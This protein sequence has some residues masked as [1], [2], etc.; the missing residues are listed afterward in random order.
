MVGVGSILL[1]RSAATFRVWDGMRGIDY[2]RSRPDIDAQRIGCTGNSGGGC[3]TSYLMALDQR[4]DCAAPSCY[5]TSFRRLMETLGPADAEQNIHGQIAHGM[6][7]TDYVLMR[8]PKPTL[9]CAATEDFMDISGSWFNFRQSKRFYTRLGYAERVDLIE[10]DAKHGFSTHLRVGATR[11]MRRWLLGRDDAVTEPDFPVLSDKECLC[12]PE[13][14][15]MF[16]PGARSTFDLNDELAAELAAARR[17]FWRETDTRV[18]LDEVRRITGIR[19]AEEL[20]KLRWMKTGV[21]QRTGYVVD[22]LILRP[23][24]G[25]WLPALAFAPQDVRRDA[26]LYVHGEGKRADAA[27]GGPIEKLVQDGYLVLAVDVRG[28][29]ETANRSPNQRHTG[30]YVGA[31]LDDV[32]IAYELGASYLA[33]RAEDVLACARFLAA[34]RSPDGPRRV[35]LVGIGD[36]GPAAL[37]AAA[38]EPQ[39]FA[40]L[41]LREC[42]L[43]W[44]DVVA[45]RPPD[46]AL[47]IN[48]VHGALRRYDLSD[49]L[50]AIP[51]EKRVVIDPLTVP[52]R[53]WRR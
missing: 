36:V 33:M 3:L 32:N 8:A 20:P 43:S 37:H 24:A 26:Y 22:K 40:S 10:A 12:A 6:G 34:Y 23:E 13:G 30:P 7:H 29:G 48:V 1:G 2:L 25:I 52:A 11:W 17:R 39:L 45:A 35:H 14:E 50:A 53:S 28:T 51:P 4:I 18:A 19:R 46:N 5:L 21:V 16:L 9:I 49:L 44:S 15:A 27:P 41:T 38:L 47:L 31:L 42:L